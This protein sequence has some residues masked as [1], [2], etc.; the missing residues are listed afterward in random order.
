M[1][2]Y[3]RRLTHFLPFV[4]VMLGNVG[5]DT[6]SVILLVLWGCCSDDV[7]SMCTVGGF[8]DIYFM[9]YMSNVGTYITSSVYK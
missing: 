2:D 7:S 6:N 3:Y 1:F 5:A 4:S 9:L 8:P